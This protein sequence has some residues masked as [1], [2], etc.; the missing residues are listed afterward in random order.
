MWL[1]VANL[2]ILLQKMANFFLK[3]LIFSFLRNNSPRKTLEAT[4]QE[5]RKICIYKVFGKK[6][7]WGKKKTKR[8]KDK[9]K[10]KETKDDLHKCGPICK[11][12]VKLPL[13]I[14]CG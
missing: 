13:N 12:N 11:L 10:I 9:R 1:N 2:N 4:Q 6:L 8:Q 7:L 3:S 5:R 14:M